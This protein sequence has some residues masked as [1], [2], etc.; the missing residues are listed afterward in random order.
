MA[1]RYSFLVYL[2][3]ALVFWVLV[4]TT[5]S[6]FFDEFHGDGQGQRTGLEEQAHE[7]EPLDKRPWLWSQ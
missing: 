3:F 2:L 7:V 1:R 5:T 4:S 6:V